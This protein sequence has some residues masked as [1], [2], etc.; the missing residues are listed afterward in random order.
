MVQA[1]VGA[2]ITNSS[3]GGARA[4][5]VQTQLEPGPAQQVLRG[6]KCATPNR[7]ATAQASAWPSES[8]QSG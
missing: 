1:G 6:L 3:A 5:C 7:E 2:E 4:D 8:S